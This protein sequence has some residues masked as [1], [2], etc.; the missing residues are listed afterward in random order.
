MALV[1]FNV[2]AAVAYL[3]L[4][5]LHG[6]EVETYRS[7]EKVRQRV[8]FADTRLWGTLFF[9]GMAFWWQARKSVEK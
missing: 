7:P 3:G 5:R 1:Y 9:A 6:R 8:L 4:I 2:V